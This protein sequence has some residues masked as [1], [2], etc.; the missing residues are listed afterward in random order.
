M[1]LGS[2]NECNQS[3]YNVICAVLVTFK[4]SLITVTNVNKMYV[5][6]LGNILSMYTFSNFIRSCRIIIIIEQYMIKFGS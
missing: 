4:L 2:S 1:P 6:G 5:F 3:I